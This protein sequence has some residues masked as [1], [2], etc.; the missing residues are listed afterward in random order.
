VF[1]ADAHKPPS[2]NTP[3][4]DSPDKQIKEVD[5]GDHRPRKTPKRSSSDESQW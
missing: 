5:G 1:G 4:A 2:R 3:N